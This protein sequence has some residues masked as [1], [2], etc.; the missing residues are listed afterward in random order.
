MLRA[1]PERRRQVRVRVSAVVEQAE[2]E[3]TSEARLQA[4]EQ[5][6]QMIAWLRIPL[7]G[8]DTESGYLRSLE[9]PETRLA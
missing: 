7:V 5:L 3:N 4:Y 9:R 1:Q 2:Q 8:G 6:R